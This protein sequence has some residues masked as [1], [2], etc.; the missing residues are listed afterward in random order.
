MKIL[1]VNA[2]YY[3]NQVGGAENVVRSLAGGMAANNI[4]TVVA[5]TA[6]RTSVDRVEGV[7]IYHVRIRN[8]FWQ[9]DNR[10]RFSLLKPWWHLIDIYN[11]LMAQ[12]VEKII[13][14][15]RP[16]LVHTHNL[17]G[18]S[19]ATWKAVK[20]KGLPLIHTVHDYHLLC[21]ANT[22]YRRGMNCVAPCWSCALFSHPKKRLSGLVDRVVSVSKFLLDR[23]TNAHYFS[24]ARCS[25]II[26][27][28]PE[29]QEPAGFTPGDQVRFGFLGQ[30]TPYKGIEILLNV[31]SGIVPGA[32]SLS[33]AGTGKGDY[34][35]FLRQ[36]YEG[37][38]IH[39]LG[40]VSPRE[41]FD[42]ID[43]LIVPSLWHEAL[44]LVILEA[45][46]FGVPVI[47][48]RRGGIPEVVDEGKTG[49]LFEPSQ[50]EELREK[51]ARFLR[52]PELAADMA[53]H[54]WAK[55]KGLA[56]SHFLQQYMEVYRGVL[57]CEI[58]KTAC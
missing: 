23:H 48:A 51:I 53:G 35:N 39:F 37:P 52:Q 32:A 26:N 46:S 38:H 50:S 49:F 16:D 27:Y 19:V 54:C 3:P 31:F 29:S 20:K 55:A 30:L 8:L 42:R 11:P 58:C 21:P 14:R 17:Q 4:E 57:G 25:V 45:Y 2:L 9:Y 13:D 24:G 6:G 40:L 44:G 10:K 15:E 12:E 41:L 43:V 56:R 33:V 34:V 7:K 47:A 28:A 18:F 1:F 5:A 22:M 36:Q